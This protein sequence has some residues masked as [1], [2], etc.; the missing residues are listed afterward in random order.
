MPNEASNPGL[1]FLQNLLKAAYQNQDVNLLLQQNLH[2][3]NDDFACLLRKWAIEQFKN[4]PNTAINLAKLIFKFSNIIQQFEQGDKN[5]NLQI[6]ILGYETSLKVCT[7][8]TCP[9]DWAKIQQA[10]SETYQQRQQ[11]LSNVIIDLKSEVE[12]HQTNINSISKNF[13]QEL[14]KTQQQVEQLTTQLTELKP[15]SVNLEQNE[16]IKNL[17]AD[18]KDLKQ[19]QSIIHQILINKDYASLTKQNFNTAVFYDIENLTMGR[20]NCNLNFSLKLIHDNIKKI[21]IVKRVSLQCAYADWSDTRLRVL[22][23]EIQKLGIEAIQIFDFG[24]RRNAA[25]IQL[26]IDA[27]EL[28]NLRPNLEVFV[29]VSGDGAFASLAKKLHEHNKTVIVCAYEGHSNR[30][31]MSVC[32]HFIPLVPVQESITD[33]NSNNVCERSPTHLTAPLRH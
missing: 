13:S 3:L 33:T 16:D 9:S 12:K 24:H 20:S 30:F 21:D 17:I 32:D 25:D 8:E 6:A 4:Q 7:Y 1:P 11:I 22:R 26:A 29:I 27:I 18:Y 2:Q 5:I 19:S 15:E 10:L 31:L 14:E 23:N 28:V